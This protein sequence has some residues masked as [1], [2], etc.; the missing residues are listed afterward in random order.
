MPYNG[1]GVFSASA[2]DFPAVSGTLIQSTKFN[3]VIND[4]ATGLTTAITKDGQT[5]PSANLP[6]GG[7]KHL[8]V[9]DGTLRNQYSSM[10]QLQDSTA[11][12]GGVA[13]GTADAL[14]L[15]TAPV[16]AAYTVGQVFRFQAG[17]SPNTGAATLS[18]SGLLAKNL[19]LN[20]VALVAGDI[21][22]NKYYTVIYDGFFH[23]QKLSP[24]FLH[25]ANTWTG[26]NTF[27][28]TATFSAAVNTAQGAD[29]A[30]AATV[31]LETATGNLVDVTG[32]VAITAI[33]LSQG[34][35]RFVRFT[36]ALTLTNGAS[37]V[38]PGG[39]NITTA[40]GDFAVFAGYAA[41]V[42]RCIS[43]VKATG[44]AVINVANTQPTRQ[45]FTSG[46][47]TY[48]TPAG[49]TRIYIRMA[50]GGAGGSGGGGAGVT[51]GGSGGSTTF[52]TLTAGGGSG[53]A[54][55]VLN[56]G[57]GGTA[58][59]GDLNVSGSGGGGGMNVINISGGNGGSNPLGFGGGVTGTTGGGLPGGY[60]GGGS[61]GSTG[62]TAGGG[63]GGGGGSYLEKLILAPAA[64]Y[65]YAV[66]ALGTAGAA[67]TNGQVGVVGTAG[68]IIV[69][70]YY[71]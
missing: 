34:H 26:L 31:N 37:L 2:A 12:W 69:D 43:Y 59:G 27:S 36:G 28:T 54:G 50:G 52:S 51:G 15:A 3:N 9:A 32:V 45:T 47:G 46:S 8:V 42:A 20:G 44:K 70:E 53:S 41:G 16:L 57:L 49:V 64:T 11:Q 1:A 24:S 56:G 6:M 25:D 10:G 39:A 18:I 67:G 38:L 13:G 21:E 65:S 55:N 19:R 30:S 63:G 29:I 40:A 4:I 62:G 33:T 22:A 23:I 68:V 60:G 66:G 14:T 17:A 35:V 58:T 48:T 71:D 5:T 7:F 61:G